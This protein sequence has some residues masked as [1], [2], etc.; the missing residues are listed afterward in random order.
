MSVKRFFSKRVNFIY[1]IT[2]AMPLAFAT[3]MSLINNFSIEVANFTGREIG[4]L[5]SVREIPGFL[6]FLA[7]YLL[8]IFTQQTLAAVSLLLLGV[9]VLLTG[10]F[11]SEYGLYATTFI[12]S[13]GFHYLET[14]KQ[15]LTLQWIPKKIAPIVFGN[16]ESVKSFAIVLAYVSIYVLFDFLQ[17][18]YLFSY[19]LFGS[20][21]I[22]LAL[23]AYFGFKHFR[24]R[25][26]QTKKIVL[27]KKYWLF[28]V[29]TF[30]S[31]ARRQI[32]VVFAG[33]LLVEKFGFS[34]QNIVLLH[35]STAIINTYFARVIG[36]FIAR[37]GERIALHL[38][39]IGLVVIFATY[40][41]VENQNLAIAL[42]IIDHILFAMAIAIK[43]Y[44]QK[45]ADGGDMA[46]SAGVSFTIN[47][48]AAVILPVLLGFVWLYSYELVF[49]CG[50]LIAL[51]SLAFSFLVP[52]KEEFILLQNTQITPTK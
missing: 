36:R 47:H 35:L 8:L 21:S 33:F 46:S 18:S 20:L 6:A 7:I 27:K 31:G 10:F 29:L 44:F 42:Y 32:F 38:E 34:V 24:D 13:V 28:Y 17:M 11:P 12:M 1:L 43:T 25:V 4:I 19:V 39:Y 41:V 30:F 52:S 49:Y 23:I 9:G 3:W 5:Q 14:V 26:F 48:I 2:L 51:C 37:V 50:A 22:V 16:I 15:S 40:A 45:I